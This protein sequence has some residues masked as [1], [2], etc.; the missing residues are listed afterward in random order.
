MFQITFDEE[1]LAEVVRRAV[2]EQMEAMM[3][4]KEEQPKER[5]ILYSM[6]ELADFIGCCVPTAQRMKNEGRI[7]Y[8]QIGRKV[9]FDTV[10]VLK[11][12]V[13]G[14]RKNRP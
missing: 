3:I 7:P 1:K 2:K 8:K 10:E 4:Q 14:K 9:M 11:A 13:P 6:K 5:R 12:M